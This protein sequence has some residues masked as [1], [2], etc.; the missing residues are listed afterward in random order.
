MVPKDLLDELTYS[1]VESKKYAL[2]ITKPHIRR[3]LCSW[4]LP[5]LKIVRKHETYCS[6]HKYRQT[7]K[8]WTYVLIEI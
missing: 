4:K 7:Q 8:F 2:A 3:L 5:D 1:V 6:S